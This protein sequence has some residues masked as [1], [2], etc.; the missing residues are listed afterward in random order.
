MDWAMPHFDVYRQDMVN[1]YDHAS[2]LAYAF[3]AGELA[4]QYDEVYANEGS[5]MRDLAQ[6]IQG[7]SR[8]R[9]VLE[10]A[11]GHGRWTRYIAESAR[12]VMATDASQRMLDQARQV[13]HWGRT[14]P[15]WRCEF[16]KL[17][18][19]HVDQVPG[20]F[21][22]AVAVNFFQHIPRARQDAFL[23]ALHRKLGS[24]AEVLIAINRL[25]RSTRARFYR[26]PGEPDQ[27]D[28]RQLKDGSVYEIV[29]NV[30]T[31]GQLGAIFAGR[32]ESY[33]FHAGAK[34]DWITYTVT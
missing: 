10:I 26:K 8:G 16:R 22:A 14:L 31:P 12:Y 34:F 9:R 2:Q 32:C 33:R 29:D 23:D 4:R 15:D 11:C 25:K 18:A 6:A 21:G 3:N 28:L 30:F 24:G 5:W 13:V 7:I 1:Y 27:F 19:F 17:D 20:E